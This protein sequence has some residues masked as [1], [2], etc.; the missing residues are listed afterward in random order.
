MLN[1]QFQHL[2]NPMLAEVSNLGN[3]R[4]IR[5]LTGMQ[6]YQRKVKWIKPWIDTVVHI[7]D[8]IRFFNANCILTSMFTEY[9]HLEHKTCCFRAILLTTG[10]NSLIKVIPGKQ[11]SG[12]ISLKCEILE[13]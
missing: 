4:N 10:H 5:I 3:L 12:Q 13:F 9:L 6:I 7:Y 8:M 1:Y 2:E 11:D